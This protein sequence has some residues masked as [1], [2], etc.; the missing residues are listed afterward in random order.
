MIF[1][2]Y[3]YIGCCRGQNHCQASRAASY[4]RWGLHADALVQNLNAKSSAHNKQRGRAGPFKYVFFCAANGSRCCKLLAGWLSACLV[5]LPLLQF[6]EISCENDMCQKLSG[7]T[8]LR[9]GHAWNLGVTNTPL[10]I[11]QNPPPWHVW[12]W[13][14]IV[15][16][17][18]HPFLD[19]RI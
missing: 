9:P 6:K 10:T 17:S 13:C 3:E 15:M 19:F 2:R 8:F 4:G 1:R 16:S 14:D 18:T 12:K 11:G 5:W 7:K